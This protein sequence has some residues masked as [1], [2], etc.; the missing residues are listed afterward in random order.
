MIIPAQAVH[1]AALA[2]H[3]TDNIR[4]TEFEDA[5][6]CRIG[7]LNPDIVNSYDIYFDTEQDAT[8]FIMRWM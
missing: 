5:Y 6:R 4:Q 1:R 8:M 3:A 7:P 2:L